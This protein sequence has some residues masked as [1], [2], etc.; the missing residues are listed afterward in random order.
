MSNPNLA[1]IP[2]M[3]PA[4]VLDATPE[5]LAVL[6]APHLERINQRVAE[7][8]QEAQQ[9]AE[10]G[11][12]PTHCV[13]GTRMVFADD[14]DAICGWCEEGLPA[15]EQALAQAQ[16]DWT[17]FCKRAQFNSA[18]RLIAQAMNV[19]I[20]EGMPGTEWMLEPISA[21]TEDNQ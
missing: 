19:Q 12:R 18:V 4:Y 1:F 20:P 10:Q 16:D 7:W 15:E 11:Y 6:A 9:A 13:H 2:R 21:L 5:A 8:Q 17:E 3:I 14:R